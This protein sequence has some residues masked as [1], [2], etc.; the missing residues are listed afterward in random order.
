MTSA[1]VHR[2]MTTAVVLSA[3]LGAACAKTD[4]TSAVDSP[5]P[6]R[7]EID[8]RPDA[9]AALATISADGLAA[10]IRILASDECE[11]RGPGTPGE[12]KTIA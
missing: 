2:R 12:E 4:D 6:G 10:D 5:A 7:I 9:A 1:R 11:G 8:I 3:A